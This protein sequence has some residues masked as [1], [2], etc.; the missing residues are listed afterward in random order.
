MEYGRLLVMTEDER[1]LIRRQSNCIAQQTATIA[2][3]EKEIEAQHS[4]EAV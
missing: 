1:D 4:Q 2:A 3:L